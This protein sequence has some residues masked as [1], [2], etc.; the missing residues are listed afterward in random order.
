MVFRP[1]LYSIPLFPVKLG[2][3]IAEK[4]RDYSFAYCIDFVIFSYL[5]ICLNFL[6]PRVCVDICLKYFLA[7]FS[8]CRKIAQYFR[9]VVAC[10]H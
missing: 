5:C 8:R 3:E 1:G 2:N 9:L 6:V 4:D 10:F 7:I